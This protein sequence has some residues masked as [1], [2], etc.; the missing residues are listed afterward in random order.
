MLEAPDAETFREWQQHPVTEW[1]MALCRKQADTM[2]SRWADLAWTEGLNETA[3]T[4]ARVRA[5]CYLALP[6]SSFEDW[7]AIDDS[8]A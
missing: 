1:V 8:E 3:F 4:E 2:K 5:D 6:E 7:K